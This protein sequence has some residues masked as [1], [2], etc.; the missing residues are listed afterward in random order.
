MVTRCDG[1]SNH[2][3]ADFVDDGVPATAMGKTSKQQVIEHHGNKAELTAYQAR[4]E[5]DHGALVTVR[6]TRR[7][8]GRP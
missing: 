4:A 7:W 5:T 3:R 2:D 8:S 6:R 1:D